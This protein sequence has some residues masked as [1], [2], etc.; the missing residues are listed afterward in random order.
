MPDM[1]GGNFDFS[2][3]PDM[4]GGNF[5]FSQMPDMSG[6]NFDFSQMPDMS[7][8]DFDF[9][10]MPGGMGGFGGFGG[11]GSSDVMLQYSDDD[12]ESY[13]NI[14][15]SAKTDV[16]EAD[17]ARLIESLKKLSEGESLEE[18]LEAVDAEAV[19][20]Y[21]VVHHFMDNGDSYTG[22]MVHNYYLY[23]ED[24]ALSLLPWDY[25]LAFGAF[26]MGGGFGGMSSGA[27]SSVN[28]PI[29][30]PVTSGNIS[31]RPI[32][33]WIFESE[34]YTARYHEVYQEFVD[35]CLSGDWL[36]SEIERVSE[37]IAPYIEADENGFFSYEEFTKAIETLREYAA[38]RVQSIAGQLAGTIPSTQ[39][40]QSSN[41]S[42]LI[43]ASHLDV[44][45]MGGMDMG[46]GFGGDRGGFTMPDRNNGGSR[47]QRP[48]SSDGSMAAPDASAEPEATI[49][50]DATS[51][52]SLPDGMDG[53]FP[54]GN[55]T[56]PDGMDGQFPGGSMTPPSGMDGQFPGGSMTPPSG[57]NPFGS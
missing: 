7:G 41:S 50:P 4:S 13:Q 35:L 29:D 21:L 3:M 27:T 46:G 12:P 8:E 42:A 43:D 37:M 1:S 22:A 11:M 34:E 32:L 15:E 10:Q 23:E 20:R 53:Q 5:D 38:L 28:A 51:A 48:S 55:M 36:S 18:K 40:E 30:T 33:S 54:G 49:L 25:N 52:P 56:L 45:D 26:S 2:Q 47:Q 9:S 39:A 24:G 44:S 17:Q 19:I 57:F 31:A 14:F 6:G 16:S